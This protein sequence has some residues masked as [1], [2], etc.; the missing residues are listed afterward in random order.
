MKKL[1]LALSLAAVTASAM[2]G[3]HVRIPLSGLTGALAAHPAVPGMS[4]GGPGPIEP[5]PE[6]E[7]ARGRGVLTGIEFG[8]VSSGI[9]IFRSAVLS[10]NGEGP[11]Q[12][13]AIAVEGAGYTLVS[14]SCGAVLAAGGDCAINIKLLPS[15]MLAHP[16]TAVVIVDGKELRAELS[17]QSRQGDLSITPAYRA[18]G[19]V[20][21]G[22]SATSSAHTLIN[23]GN[24][25]VTELVL[26]APAGYAITSSTCGSTI[27]VG[28]RCTF[29]FRFTPTAVKGYDSNS[30]IMTAS[31]G[32]HSIS[33]TGA[34]IAPVQTAPVLKLERPALDFGYQVIGQR[35]IISQTLRNS[36]TAP[37]YISRSSSTATVFPFANTCGAVIQPG[38][39]CGLNVY[40]EPMY[41]GQYG[42]SATLEFSNHAPL[43][44]DA[45]GYGYVE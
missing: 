16:G 25:P 28:A 15:G 2:A 35:G 23:M 42:G 27:P 26:S 11:L 31:S 18:F 45:S 3:N 1:L 39:T 6:P 21:V 36:G 29:A 17:A 9:Q 24:I 12:L 44:I 38:A 4:G 10:N 14:N 32:W 37:A 41:E 40:F 7:P 43:R 30:V 19:N 5:K 34:G 20:V 8:D 13:S 22:E 33:L